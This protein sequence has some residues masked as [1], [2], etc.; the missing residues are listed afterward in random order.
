MDDKCHHAGSMV[1]AC[2]AWFLNHVVLCLMHDGCCTCALC[3]SIG[4]QAG[5]QSQRKQQ[6]HKKQQWPK[7][8]GATGAT[9]ARALAMAVA[10]EDAGGVHG[11]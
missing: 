3:G 4:V 2:E 8:Q 10:Q 7:L 6:R 5:W 9:A 11:I 1:Y